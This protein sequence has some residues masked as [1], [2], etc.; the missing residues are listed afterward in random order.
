MKTKKKPERIP[1][2][3]FEGIPEKNLEEILIIISV[4]ISE[5]CLA[6]YITVYRERI[7]Y[8]DRT[9]ERKIL[10]IFIC[11]L[12]E[13][14][15]RGLLKKFLMKFLEKFFEKLN[16]IHKKNYRIPIST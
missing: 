16:K 7:F 9:F 11:E 3:C 4:E 10:I 1:V 14:F 12:L 13:D 15:L 8:S 6:S 2:E 5:E